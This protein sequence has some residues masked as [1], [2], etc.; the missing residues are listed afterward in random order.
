MK[1]YSLIPSAEQAG[2]RLDIFILDFCQ[3][4]NL[5]YSR[6][7]IQKLIQER[8]V[9]FKG[10]V[11]LKPH[12]KIKTKDV[13]KV[14]VEDKLPCELEAEN[15]A[16]DVIY[17]DEDIAVINKDAGLVVHPAPGNYEHT[18]VNALLY[19]IKRLSDINPARPGIVHRLDKETSGI[20]VVAKNN[21][22]HL[23]LAR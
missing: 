3:K 20:L 15:I 18:L 16:L 22:S 7:F 13:L 17:E 9:T 21:L 6:T 19:R 12:Y 5:G 8:K 4:N 1:E 11:I 2:M 14:S 10:K 23:A